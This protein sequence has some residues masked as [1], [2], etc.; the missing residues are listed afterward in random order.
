MLMKKIIPRLVYWLESPNAIHSTCLSSEGLFALI[1]YTWKE[2][3]S[4][5]NMCHG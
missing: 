3:N 4:N 5:H 1:M 2:N